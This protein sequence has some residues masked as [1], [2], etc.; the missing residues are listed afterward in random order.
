[1]DE[2]NL[3]LNEF[4]QNVRYSLILKQK[5]DYIN[6][7]RIESTKILRGKIM[8][9]LHSVTIEST[10]TIECPPDMYLEDKK[11]VLRELLSLGYPQLGVNYAV[12]ESD[13]LQYV[14]GENDINRLKDFNIIE[15]YI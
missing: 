9:S 13:D 2:S 1:M 8:S 6:K 15:I 4:P 14:N 10:V 7:H 11:S 12:L 3:K 5:R